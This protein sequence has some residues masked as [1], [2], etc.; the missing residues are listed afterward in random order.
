MGDPFST[1]PSAIVSS[2]EQPTQNDPAGARFR[3]EDIYPI[4][5]CG[6]AAVKGIAGQPITVWADIFR[7]GHDEMA[8]AVRWRRTSSRRWNRSPMRFHTND[9]TPNSSM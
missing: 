8:A 4:V 3:I 9:R 5:D 6:R 7:D 1:R 2:V